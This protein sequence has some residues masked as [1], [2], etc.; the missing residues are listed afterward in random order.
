MQVVG[1]VRACMRACMRV[2]ASPYFSKMVVKSLKPLAILHKSAAAPSP[3]TNFTSAVCG[4]FG[5]L[6]GFCDKWPAAINMCR[7]AQNRIYTPY[8][9][10]FP[11]QKFRIYTK[12]IW[13]RPTLNMWHDCQKRGWVFEHKFYG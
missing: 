11:S 13:F 8:I 12:Y 10:W 2:Q 9:W 6:R 4:I 1:C 7:V 3:P 5:G